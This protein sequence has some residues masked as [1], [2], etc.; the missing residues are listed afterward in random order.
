MRRRLS[1]EARRAGSASSDVGAH[2]PRP[3]PSHLVAQ[4]HHA[5]LVGCDL[6][7]MKRDVSVELVEKGNPTP[8]Q[9]REDRIAKLVGEP[10]TKAFAAEGAA[11]NEPDA[12]ERGSQTLIH[13]LREI[14]RVEFDRVA[15]P[16]EIA[17]REHE[18]WLLPVG[19]SESLGFEAQRGLVGSRSHDIA[20]DRLEKLFDE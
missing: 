12:A 13:E 11:S 7:Q 1:I 10:E 14:A 3:L 18:G 16:W 19:P 20:V 6:R 8:D 2:G 5:V 9:D 4:L 17:S 15:G